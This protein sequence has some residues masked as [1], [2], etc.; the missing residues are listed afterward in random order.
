MATLLEI[1][2]ACTG[3]AHVRPNFGTLPIDRTLRLL[4]ATNLR[5]SLFAFE[6]IPGRMSPARLRDIVRQVIDDD[7]IAFELDDGR[8]GA[9]VYGWRPPGAPDSWVE[10][11]TIDRLDWALGG[12]D[13]SDDAIEVYASHRWSA[14]LSDAADIG[15]ALAFAT[16]VGRPAPVLAY[17]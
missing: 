1:G 12:P 6:S 2:P 8:I 9:L 5:L 13:A 4:G 11:R 15:A 7:R 10:D 14:E 3:P 16:P 17:A